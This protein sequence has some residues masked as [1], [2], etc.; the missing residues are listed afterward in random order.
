MRRPIIY[1]GIVGLILLTACS[2]IAN[3]DE[4]S[5]STNSAAPLSY[6]VTMESDIVEFDEYHITI[7]YPQTPNNQINQT[8]IDYVNQRK[9]AFKKESYQSIQKHGKT[10]SHEL[11]IDFEVLHQGSSFFVVRFE[12]SMDVGLP[13]LLHAQTIMNFDK[14]NG[15]RIEPDQL[16]KEDRNYV[17]QLAELTKEELMKET[18]AEVFHSSELQEALKSSYLENIA[19]TTKGIEVYLNQSSE[20][21]PDKIVLGQRSIND[22]LKEEFASALKAEGESRREKKTSIEDPPS[23]KSEKETVVKSQSDVK[24]VAI[25][26]DDGPHP[27]VTPEILQ[28]L[29]EYK[30][31]ATFFMIG[32]RVNYFPEVAQRVAEKG[33]EIG[34]HT[35][36][37]SRLTRLTPEEVDEQISK[38]QEIIEEVTGVQPEVVRLPFGEQPPISQK[39][40]QVI[41]SDVSG[42]NWQG[43][44][45]VELAQDMINE[46]KDG[47]VILLHDLQGSTVEVLELVLD[48]LS[49]QGYQFVTVSEL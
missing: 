38:T 20:K 3:A 24:K 27:K 11:H 19:L 12:E 36:D 35:W 30:A 37:H 39:N 26:F 25:T 13:T 34:N 32:K 18:G 15:K 9:A 42:E 2:F 1:I 10:K 8:I 41:P 23:S 7:H 49:R 46:A 43:K 17:D 28:V 16:F 40:L 22:L 48:A 47:D 14:K 6:E 5:D 44:E 21:I 45:A 33:H 31:K 4:S 29:D